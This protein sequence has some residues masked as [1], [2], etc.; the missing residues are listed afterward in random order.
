M[1]SCEVV[2]MRGTVRAPPFQVPRLSWRL[3][4]SHEFNVQG[5]MFQGFQPT[6]K[7]LNVVSI[8]NESAIASRNWI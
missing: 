1:R 3:V 8:A 6:V 5:S 7:G 2:D 4:S